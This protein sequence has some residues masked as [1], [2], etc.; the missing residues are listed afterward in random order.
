[1]QHRCWGSKLCELLR[2]VSAHA[3]VPRDWAVQRPLAVMT[4]CVF[5]TGSKGLVAAAECGVKR[6]EEH[7][8]P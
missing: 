1:M 4:C 6:D 5:C 7:F 2:D 8:K 3:D